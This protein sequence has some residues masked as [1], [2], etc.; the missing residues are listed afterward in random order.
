MSPVHIMMSQFAQLA[1]SEKEIKAVYGC[2]SDAKK[3]DEESNDGEKN[4]VR[5]RYYVGHN[6]FKYINPGKR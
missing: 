1:M 2:H 4:L 3:S 5:K 6:Q